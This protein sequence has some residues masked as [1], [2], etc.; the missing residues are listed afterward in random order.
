MEVETGQEKNRTD[1]TRDVEYPH[2]Y[3]GLVWYTH[4]TQQGLELHFRSNL[5]LRTTHPNVRRDYR[6]TLVLVWCPNQEWT[7]LGDPRLLTIHSVPYKFY[8]TQVGTVKF[9]SN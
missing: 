1:S 8:Q 2:L 4:M 3:L 5:F 7:T 9:T 6:Y